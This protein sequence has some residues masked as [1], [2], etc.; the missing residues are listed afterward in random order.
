MLKVYV[1]D[2][3][4]LL[5]MLRELENVIQTRGGV[6]LGDIAKIGCL[7]GLEAFVFDGQ[8]SE[9]LVG[10]FGCRRGR[11]L[12]FCL[13]PHLVCPGHKHGPVKAKA[14][15]GVVNLD[16]ATFVQHHCLAPRQ[17]SFAT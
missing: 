14:V 1:E 10:V 2:C 16:N 13:L 7:H 17:R 12:F 8:G 5:E 9:P 15:V 6:G 11:I 4:V 3:D